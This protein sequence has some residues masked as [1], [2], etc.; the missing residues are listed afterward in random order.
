MCLIEEWR[1]ELDT[2]LDGVVTIS[3]KFFG[4]T[5][6]NM[7]IIKKFRLKSEQNFVTL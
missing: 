6:R 2:F 4:R 7:L 5:S 1:K 3:Y